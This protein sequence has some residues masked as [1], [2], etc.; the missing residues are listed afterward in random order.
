MK[1]AILSILT[2]LWIILGG[3]GL[4][5]PIQFREKVSAPLTAPR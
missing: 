2:I 3:P 1:G 5:R 4:V